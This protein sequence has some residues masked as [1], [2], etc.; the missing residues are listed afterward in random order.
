[1]KI[2]LVAFDLDGTLLDNKKQISA[3]NRA[4]LEA[5]AKKGVY[6][7]PCTARLFNKMPEQVRS[8]PFVRCAITVNGAEVFDRDKNCAVCRAEIPAAEAEILYDYMDGLPVIYDCYQEGEG[9]IDRYF[10][11]HAL[12]LTGDEHTARLIAVTRK[13]LERFRETMRERGLP[14][15]KTQMFFKDLDLRTEK[16]RQIKK[17]FP[18]YSV[19]GSLYN[20]I[21]IN[22]GSANKGEALLR[23]CEYIRISPS[24]CMAI[25]DGNNDVSMLKA[26]GIGVAM[27]NAADEVKAFAD[28][29]TASNEESGV[30]KAIRRY[31]LNS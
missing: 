1:M 29:V 6:L 11:E 19:T 18:L 3:E 21:E 27:D 24:E 8:L 12:E 17:E 28:V 22:A 23:L 14:I 25:G 16:M 31:V 9:Y 10:Y 4:A 5:A 13:P 7:V 30:A 2:R 20:N 15:Q 26:A